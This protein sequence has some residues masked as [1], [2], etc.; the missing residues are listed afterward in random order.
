[1]GDSNFRLEVSSCFPF[2]EDALKILGVKRHH[3]PLPI[4][5]IWLYHFTSWEHRGTNLAQHVRD[6]Y[7]KILFHLYCRNSYIILAGKS[8]SRSIYSSPR[9]SSSSFTRSWRSPQPVVLITT[10]CFSATT[11][12]MNS[13]LDSMERPSSLDCRFPTGTAV[14]NERRGRN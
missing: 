13:L 8:S 6:P 7:L 11:R 4:T 12:R 5:A 1:M 3:L 9:S 2:S 14:R 10:C